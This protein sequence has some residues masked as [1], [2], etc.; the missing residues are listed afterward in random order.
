MAGD[1]LLYGS[2]GYV[3][4]AI[5]E[6]AVQRGLRP[7]LGGRDH[8]AVEGQ[9][10]GLDLDFVIAETRDGA[11]LDEMMAAVPVVLSCAGPFLHT[12]G[13]VVEA[14]LRTGTH[15][16]DI[17]GE[18]PVYEMI[19]AHH[20]RAAAAGL[21]LLPSVG[22][23]VVPTDCLAVHLAKRLPT[24]TRL[25]IAL[26]QQG[27]AGLP[28]GT[29]NTLI[30]LTPHVTTR[31]HRVDGEVVSASR[32]LTRMIDFGEG[33]VAASMITWGD[34]FT[35]YRSTEI[36]NIEEYS[37]LSEDLTGQLD[38]LDRLRPLLR[39][40][41]VRWAAKRSL[42]GGATAAERAETTMSVWAEVTD[43]DGG[44]AVSRL[45]GP[46]GGLEWTSRVAV[47]VLSH[48]LDG[49]ITPGFQTPAMAYG[50]D[51]VLETEGVRREDLE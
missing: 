25:A 41:P 4:S 6:L 9:A 31:E 30:E 42:R 32:R 46:E 36:P 34:V 18:P 17:S 19:A 29:L 37:V 13:P 12:A 21:M 22:F 27:P 5:A 26:N 7:I 50:P 8:E 11:A 39:F 51:L 40:G 38:R 3:G 49:D 14:C 35:A 23:D 43:G 2:T 44:K 20:N 28:P 33:P 47:D 48:A 16:L 15:Y 10:R 45:H 1:F 24:A